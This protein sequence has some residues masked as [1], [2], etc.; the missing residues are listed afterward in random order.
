[1]RVIIEV[2]NKEELQETLLLLGDRPVEVR[3]RTTPRRERLEQIFRTYQGRLPENYR[4]DRDEAHE[5]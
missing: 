3:E 1:M 4:F 5:R 2:D